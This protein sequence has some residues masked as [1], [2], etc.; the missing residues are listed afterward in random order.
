MP[1]YD[2]VTISGNWLDQYD[3][4]RYRFHM[5]ER[6]PIIHPCPNF[7]GNLAGKIQAFHFDE[8]GNDL[9]KMNEARGTL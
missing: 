5:K 9:F 3:I 2:W 8:S 4:D 6:D 7:C 1:F